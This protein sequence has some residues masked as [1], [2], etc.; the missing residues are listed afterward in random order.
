MRS[1]NLLDN[2]A[3]NLGNRSQRQ[4]LHEK[5]LEVRIER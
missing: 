3:N 2:G 1:I 5:D 4:S